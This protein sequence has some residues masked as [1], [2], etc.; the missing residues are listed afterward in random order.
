M[1]KSRFAEEQI[2]NI[3][4]SIESGQKSR[5]LAALMASLSRLIIAGKPSTAGST[6]MKHVTSNNSNIRIAGSR[7]QSLI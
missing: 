2:I 1:R 7:Q 6:S 4:K 5:T 3:L